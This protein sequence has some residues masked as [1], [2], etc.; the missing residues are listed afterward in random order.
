MKQY[1]ESVFG[2][3][4]SSMERL[5]S[6]REIIQDAASAGRLRVLRVIAKNDPIVPF[7]TIDVELSRRALDRCIVM[8]RGGHCT[9]PNSIVPAIR[10]YVAGE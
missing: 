9:V 5:W 8:E 2:T 6:C 10:Q 4:W 3:E 1:T 7:A